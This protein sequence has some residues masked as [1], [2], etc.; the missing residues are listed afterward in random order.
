MRKAIGI[1]G[2]LVL[3]TMAGARAFAMDGSFE[4]TLSDLQRTA[5]VAPLDLINWKVGDKM[6][7]NV[8]AG[9]FGKLGTM[10][11]TVT[12]DE[13]TSLWF[14]Q[15]MALMTQNEVI[16]IQIN[17]ADGKILKMIRNGQE[18]QIPDEQIEIISQ[19]YTEIKVPAG[20]FKALHIV[21]KTKSISKLEAWINPRDTV[22][23]GTLK[24]D[25]ATQMGINLVMELT[26][27]A[28]GQ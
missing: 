22:M 20:N 1:L 5:M 28:H 17:K 11:K 23:D 10:T 19:D 27:F 25:M 8:S 24:Q 13:G 26:S 6:D 21:A 14:R 3:T 2:I 12:K 7:Y 18:Q 9:A 15:Q 16:D 4:L